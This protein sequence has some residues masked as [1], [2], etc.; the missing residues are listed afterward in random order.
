MAS[1][2]AALAYL[3]EL[4]FGV[5]L[6]GIIVSILI[7]GSDLMLNHSIKLALRWVGIFGVL[8]AIFYLSN[9]G[10]AGTGGAGPSGD[11]RL[12][13]ATTSPTPTTSPAQFVLHFP[14]VI[15]HALGARV[16][17]ISAWMTDEA[18][19][20]GDIYPCQ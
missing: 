4:L 18:G 11:G 19:N 3:I 10:L 9:S 5:L 15:R 16:E 20:P 2:E 7:Y 6:E 17:L 14:N 12:L 1:S 13:L 8:V